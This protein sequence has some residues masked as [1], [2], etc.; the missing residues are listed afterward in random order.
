MVMTQSFQMIGEVTAGTSS[1]EETLKRTA[2]ENAV[3][4]QCGAWRAITGVEQKEKL[5]DEGAAWFEVQGEGLRGSQGDRGL[6][7]RAELQQVT[8]LDL[9]ES[10]VLGRRAVVSRLRRDE[11]GGW[12]EI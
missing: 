12:T 5:E 11:L 9:D 6:E 10:Y 4:N 8:L 2:F 1:E 7:S 3:C